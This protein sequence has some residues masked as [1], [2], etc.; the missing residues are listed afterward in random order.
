MGKGNRTRKQQAANVL[1]T[2]GKKKNA[3]KKREMPTWAGTLI[4]VAVLVAVTLFSVFCI[5]NSRGVFLRNKIIVKSDNYEITVPM[6]SYMVYTEYQEWVNN[7]QDSGYMQFIKGE[8][9]DGLNT[10]LPLREQNYSKKTDETTGVTTTVTWFD[11]FA[12]RAAS[13]VEQILV[14]CEQAHRLGI[15]LDDEKI[16]EID[17]AMQTLDLY[18]AYNGYTTAGYIAAM[19]GRGVSKKDVRAMTEMIELATKMTSVKN[20]EFENGATDVRIENY[21][22]ENKKEID[23]YVDFISYTFETEFKP[24]ADTEADAAN[25]NATAYEKYEADKK[26]YEE[27]VDAL[28]A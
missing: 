6:M 20:E 18:A 25:K 23:I 14:L 15:T 21:Y 17:G 9:G 3:A 10:S 8:G 1:S 13:S 7:Y 2:A 24:V 28:A 27:R 4:V 19:Y 26:K 22:N 5:L 11:Y 16:K 12:D